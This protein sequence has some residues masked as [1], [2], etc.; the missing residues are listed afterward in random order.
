MK[1]SLSHDH[2]SINVTQPAQM[3]TMKRA[4]MMISK[5]LAISL[6]PIMTAGTMEKML[7]NSRVPFLRQ[8]GWMH[9][10][11]VVKEHVRLR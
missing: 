5:D 1:T 4:A 8:N 6:H 3:P 11:S 7:L 9:L 2:M 10:K